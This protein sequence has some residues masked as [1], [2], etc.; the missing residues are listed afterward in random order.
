MGI[1]SPHLCQFKTHTGIEAP[2]VG[3][4]PSELTPMIS[5]QRC[6]ACGHREL[7]V[8]QPPSLPSP[9]CRNCGAQWGGLAGTLDPLA[10]FI[11]EVA[12]NKKKSRTRHRRVRAKT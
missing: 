4:H 5:E 8:G 12:M 6:H 1:N 9:V 2:P 11:P 3:L 7:L 10:P